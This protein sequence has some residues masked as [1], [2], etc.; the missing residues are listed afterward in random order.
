MH[1]APNS[2]RDEVAA[3]LIFGGELA[4]GGFIDAAVLASPLVLSLDERCRSAIPAG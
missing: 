1:A 4:P 3:K 2:L